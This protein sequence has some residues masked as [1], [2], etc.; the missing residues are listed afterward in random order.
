MSPAC[1]V[2]SWTLRLC[3]CLGLALALPGCATFLGGDERPVSQVLPEYDP[4][5][6]Q[7]PAQAEAALLAVDRERRRRDWEWDRRAYACYDRFLLNRCLNAVEL[8]RRTTGLRYK[9]IEVQARQVLR[10]ERA[11]DSN[12]GRAERIEDAAARGSGPGAAE[13]SGDAVRA[14]QQREDEAAQRQR[15]RAQDDSGKAGSRAAG[16][17][18]Q[19]E[20]E[21]EVRARR[22]RAREREAGAPARGAAWQARRA[23]EEADRTTRQSRRTRPEA[24]AQPGPATD[25]K[26]EG[27]EAPAVK[28]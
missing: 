1:P 8:E 28:D 14:R 19:R 5:L 26:G 24:S 2:S 7:T 18:R 16:L 21:Q 20:R 12:L 6:I 23:E 22:E 3:W 4:S 27:A 15:D 9:Q 13:A 11:Y 10:N 25:P 17:A